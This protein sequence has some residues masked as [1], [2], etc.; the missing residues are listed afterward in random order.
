MMVSRGLQAIYLYCK[1]SDS[2]KGT[3]ST[4]FVK[5]RKCLHTGSRGNGGVAREGAEL[6]AILVD[7]L[8]ILVD[9][10]TTLG[11]LDKVGFAEI[12]DA[13]TAR[14]MHSPCLTRMLQVRQHYCSDIMSASSA[15]APRAATHA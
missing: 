1:F 6:A 12:A 10:E 7:L 15:C 11:L 5:F 8:T 14:F 4:P 13:P 9:L 2:S 3:A